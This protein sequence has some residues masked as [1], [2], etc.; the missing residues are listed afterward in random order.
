MRQGVFYIGRKDSSD[1]VVEHPSVSE[2]HASL[3]LQD[4]KQ[5]LF[6][7]HGRNPTWITTSAGKVWQAWLTCLIELIV[8][9]VD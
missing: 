2:T 5:L 7:N 9:F 4:D 1:I 8:L 6:K 3:D